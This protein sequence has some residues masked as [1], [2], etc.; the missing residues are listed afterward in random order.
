MRPPSGEPIRMQLSVQSKL[1]IFKS[2]IEMFPE[3]VEIVW[4]ESKS[5][6]E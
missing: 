2:E 5:N 3:G 6:A 1:D 4:K